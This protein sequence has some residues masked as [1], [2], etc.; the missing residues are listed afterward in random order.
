[1]SLLNDMLYDL[2]RQKKTSSE[3][4]YQPVVHHNL[5]D[6]SRKLMIWGGVAGFCTLALFSSVWM[7]SLRNHQ[8]PIVA[9]AVTAEG[10]TP[11]APIAQVQQP[12]EAALPSYIQP[13][14]ALAREW[15][16]VE[17]VAIESME[18]LAE[19]S[20]KKSFAPPTLEEWH[21]DEMSKAIEAIHRGDDDHA[22]AILNDLI[23]KLP[24]ALD[25]REN[26]ASL[27]LS[28]GDL[29]QAQ[30]VAE[31]G[32]KYAPDSAALLTIKGRILIAQERYEEARLLLAR[33]QPPM[34]G[35][36]DYYA[37]LA[38]A[39]Q[40]LGLTD[41][42][43]TIYKSLLQVVPD[44]GQYWLGYAIF[45]E[46]RNRINEAVDAYNRANQNPD[47]EAAVKEYAQNRINHLQG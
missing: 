19:A 37:T 4:P 34:S 23:A 7:A 8:F 26:L 29:E 44:N 42:A 45:L 31:A 32:L 46:H 38:A 14:S 13:L 27:Y 17:R 12:Q 25:A 47:S 20:I 28:Y 16:P 30:E 3:A 35:F 41:E 2:A 24:Q 43:G 15:V 5:N 33:H 1:M 18:R 21:E 10:T 9:P 6:N 36:P 11:A 40:A 22:I 39:M